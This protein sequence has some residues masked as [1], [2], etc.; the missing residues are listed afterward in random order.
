MKILGIIGGMGPLATVDLFGKIVNQTEANSDNDH[1]HILIDNNTSIPDRTS[2]ILGKGKNPIDEIVS[3]AIKLENMGADFLV[4]PCNTAHYFY[5]D[6][7]KNISIPFLNMIDETAKY[8][9]NNNTNTK[10]VGLLSTTGTIQAKVYDNIFEKYN[11]E[12]VKP[13]TKY[14]QVIMN[15]IYGI[16]K[17][18]KKFDMDEIYTVLNHLKE[19]EVECIILG[20]TELP[21]AFEMLNI[22]GE[23]IDPTYVIARACVRKAI[24]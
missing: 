23:Y 17:G 22:E 6:I 18:E 4:M 1:I 3:S 2:Y 19:K 5:N 16:K 9:L 11:I 24:I 21:V 13:E 14:Q 12:V 20:C 15:L 7:I 10:K 8:I